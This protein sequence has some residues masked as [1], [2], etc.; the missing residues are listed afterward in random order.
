MYADARLSKSKYQN[1]NVHLER[2]CGNKIL[3]PYDSINEAK[4]LC[5]PDGIEVNDSGAEVDFKSLL[6]HTVK[7]ILIKFDRSLLEEIQNEIL[8]LIGKWGMDGASGQQTTR[9]KWRHDSSMCES[10][11]DENIPID[12]SNS[13]CDDN[14]SNNDLQ[15]AEPEVQIQSENDATVF[16]VSF[17]PLQLQAGDRIIWTNS[18]PNSVHTCRT[19]QFEFRKDTDD[20]VKG[21]YDHF[22]SELEKVQISS[23][24]ID[25]LSFNGA[26]DVKCTMIDGKV[27]N[28]LTGQRATNSCNICGVGPKYVNDFDH[29]KSRQC[30][31]EFYQF[32]LSSL[33]CKIRCMEYLLKI[34]YSS[35]YKRPQALSEQ[36]KNLREERKRS[37]QKLLK[38]KLSLTV[39]V[40]KQ[41][42]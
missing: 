19:V 34:A 13:D 16:I 12:L 22:I 9:Q 38:S 5:Y 3:L 21:L 40:V 1:L 36:E 29:V 41:R 24:K 14:I 42:A 20:Y 39:D 27:C 32:G 11:D 23:I 37:I 17:S 26:F 31:E 10:D 25:D 18:T 7:R 2:I 15:E 4:K 33:H 8:L 30:S 6:I 35:D 28:S